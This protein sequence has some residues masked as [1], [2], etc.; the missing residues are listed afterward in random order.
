MIP[1]VKNN[2]LLLI[3]GLLIFSCSGTR[4]L[5]QGE[6]LYTGAEIKMKSSGSTGIKKKAEDA[7]E[8]AVRPLPN[9]GL[10]WYTP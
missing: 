3:L 2:L 5:P 6:K 10:F 4:H 7:A 1:L 8:A 9:K